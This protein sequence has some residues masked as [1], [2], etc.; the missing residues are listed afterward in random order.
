MFE[1][2]LGPIKSTTATTTSTTTTTTPV[3]PGDFH[4][5]TFNTPQTCVDCWGRHI[6]Y[7]SL[8]Y[9]D[10]STSWAAVI[11]VICNKMINAD[12]RDVSLRWLLQFHLSHTAF[13]HLHYHQLHFL[14]LVQSFIV[15]LR[16]GCSENP[17][18]HRP[19]PL[20][21]HCIFHRLSDHLMF[22]FC[23]TAGFVCM[24]C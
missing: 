21:P 7:Y 9:Y 5:C 15:K 23:S 3:L 13:Y 22:S 6:R 12:H 18:P 11:M 19:F 17:L 8:I 16:L 4:S 14:L 20:L 10:M 24:A 1:A 2:T